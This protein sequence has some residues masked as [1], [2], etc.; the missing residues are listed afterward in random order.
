MD[1]NI[2]FCLIRK[3]VR[4]ERLTFNHKI[5]NIYFLLFFFFFAHFLSTRAL[6]SIDYE[7]P[8]W[9]TNDNM[10]VAHRNKAKDI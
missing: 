5:S 10:T 8:T 9:C 2:F 1:D 6:V 7:K 4:K 3:K